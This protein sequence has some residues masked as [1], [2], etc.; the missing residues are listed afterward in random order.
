METEEQL[1]ELES[2]KVSVLFLLPKENEEILKKYSTF[3]M[4]YENIKFGYSFS[5]EIKKKLEVQQKFGFVIFRDFDDGK[6]FL[7]LDE[8][9]DMSGFKN[10]FEALR[11]PIVMKFD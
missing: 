7:V 11:F 8:V 3:T 2:E 1:K 6:K 9:S 10:F 4:N 5:E